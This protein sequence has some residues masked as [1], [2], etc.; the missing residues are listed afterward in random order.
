MFVEHI[1]QSDLY[2]LTLLTPEFIFARRGCGA[3]I[4]PTEAAPV[5]EGHYSS[6]VQ[7]LLCV[8]DHKG[9]FSLICI[10]THGF[11]VVH[12]SWFVRVNLRWLCVLC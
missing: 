12:T 1:F 8:Q 11:S 2:L 4:A 9:S 6:S 3:P 10:H 7:G 5:C